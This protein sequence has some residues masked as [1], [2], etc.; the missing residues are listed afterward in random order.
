MAAPPRRWFS[1]R[2]RTLLVVVAIVAV[3]LAWI[4]KERAESRHQI[5]VA[6][7][8][9]APG[10]NQIEFCGPF[11]LMEQ[12]GPQGGW[13]SVAEGLL[14]K[15]VRSIEGSHP[16]LDDLSSLASFTKLQTLHIAPTM[17]RDLSPLRECRDLTS[18]DLGNSPI[19][20]LSPLGEHFRLQYL[21]LG[22]T[23]VTDVAPLRGMQKLRMLYLNHT[24]VHDVR[25][26]AALSELRYL[27]LAGCQ[28]SDI[29]PLAGLAE[30]K[31]LH[32]EKNP[33]D[34]LTP[35]ARLAKLEFLCIED[36]RVTDLKP[37]AGLTRLTLVRT[38]GSPV[39]PEQL[40]ALRKAL[41]NCNVVHESKP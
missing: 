36:T 40:E 24:Q 7:Q 21:N 29:K 18:V 41:P 27:N 20:D 38:T 28:V 26:L 2:L 5:R 6:N 17:V 3:P 32:L 33:I 25:P 4:A 12:H 22:G 35:L 31:S 13:R 30:L 34:D 11:D 9:Q 23:Q 8:F 37:L 19:H 10:G 39:T 15:R 14:G 1:F 16:E